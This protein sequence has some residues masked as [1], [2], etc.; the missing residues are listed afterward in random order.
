MRRAETRLKEASGYEQLD[1]EAFAYRNLFLDLRWIS[2]F[3]TYLVIDWRARPNLLALARVHG[4]RSWHRSTSHRSPP[5]CETARAP[6]LS[7]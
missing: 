4:I 1:G 7:T 2:V 3:S 5:R 6:S